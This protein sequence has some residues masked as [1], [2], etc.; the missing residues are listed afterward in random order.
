MLRLRC[1]PG[2]FIERLAGELGMLKRRLL[3]LG[4]V[5]PVIVRWGGRD[6][7]LSGSHGD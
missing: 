2:I 6:I 4:I 7:L 5:D 1:H 3:F